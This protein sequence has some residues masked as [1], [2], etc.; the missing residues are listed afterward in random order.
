MG[1]GRGRV[2]P[3]WLWFIG[4]GALVLCYLACPADDS[5]PPRVTIVTP[6]NGDTVRDR[7][8]VKVHAVD[9]RSVAGVR[10]LV[11]GQPIG[12]DTVGV[13]DTFQFVWNATGLLP[14]TVHSLTGS[15]WDANS[16]RGTASPVQVVIDLASG[17]HHSGAITSNESWLAKDNPHVVDGN[18]TVAAV[19]TIGPGAIVLMADN[20]AIVVGAQAPAAL[21]VLGKAD[22]T[23]FFGPLIPGAGAW[24]S[25]QFL[26]SATADSNILRYCTIEQGGRDNQGMVYL[27]NSSV[28]LEFCTLRASASAGIVARQAGFTSFQANAIVNCAGFPIVIDPD[29]T[30]TLA[31]GTL[32]SGNNPDRIQVNPGTV[33]HTGCWPNLGCAYHIAGTVTVAGD[34]N[35]LLTIAAGCSLLFTDSARLR[36]GVGKPGALVANGAY[37]PIYF[38]PAGS[39]A[40]PGIQFWENTDGFHTVLQN[41]IIAHAG[42]LAG[43]AVFCYQTQIAVSGTSIEN[44]RSLG[45]Y[46][47]GCGFSRFTN[48]TI[49]GSADYPIHIEAPFVGSMGPGN[50]LTGNSRDLIEVVG[51]TISQNA[52]W[53]N[54][55]VPYLITD[56]VDVGSGA[57]PTLVIDPG[58][59]LLFGDNT[60]LRLGQTG[61]ATLVAVGNDQDSITFATSCGPPRPGA[62]RGIELRFTTTSTTILDHCR[63]LY[64]GGQGP[65]ILYINNCVPT[66]RNC[67]IGWS[68]NYCVALFNTTLEPDSLRRSNWLHDW[69]SNYED[70]YEGGPAPGP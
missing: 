69:D 4:C 16:N 59:T 43:A 64:G 44:S 35:P 15:A 42:A 6:A 28:A 56:N 47:L 36:V 49:T 54:Q 41:C 48:N 3:R 51:G 63:L 17:T 26:G 57:A 66:V 23:I 25:I 65:G 52:Q 70:I 67:E 19:L 39:G 21:K 38:G 8:V 27:E 50:R 53:R 60:M 1:N 18:L 31:A 29:K 9:N 11:D 22:S 5:E 12:D 7:V 40:W 68:A 32:F 20:A 45:V 62:W 2:G 24:R 61:P 34:S 13:D 10:L 46:C 30:G 33:Q 14:G 37:G 58:T 55:G